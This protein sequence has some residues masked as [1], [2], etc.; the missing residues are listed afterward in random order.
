MG[1][2]VLLIAVTGKDEETIHSEYRVTPTGQYEEI[3]ESP[4]TGAFLP[5]GAYLLYVN[6]D[7]TP[8]EKV[9]AR[10]S[11]NAALLACYANETIM[12]CY[13]SSWFN[14]TE[15][16][17]VWHDAQQGLTHLETTG[18]VP[19][20]LT[21]IRDRLFAEQNG[22]TDTDYIFDIPIE[23]FVTLGGVRYNEDIPDTVP[24]PWQVLNRIGPKRSWWPFSRKKEIPGA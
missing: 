20:Q 18:A 14:G 12:D 15:Q 9:F 24:E 4:V 6:D 21:A 17:S 3:A 11:E 19:D 8:N 22:V 2:R 5:N 13:V 1:Y 16:W 7:I 10:L 23:L